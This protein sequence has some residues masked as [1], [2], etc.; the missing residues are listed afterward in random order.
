VLDSTLLIF[1]S[2][3]FRTLNHHYDYT[4]DWTMLKQC[5]MQGG[6]SAI[7]QGQSDNHQERRDKDK[8]PSETALK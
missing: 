4:Y 2:I 1:H 5:G 7:P 8:K 3:L 6:A